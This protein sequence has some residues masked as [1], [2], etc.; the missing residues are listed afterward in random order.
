MRRVLVLIG[1][2]L[3]LAACGGGDDSTVTAS[4]AELEFGPQ[5]ALASADAT[6][7]TNP[8]IGEW[9]DPDAPAV[10]EAPEAISFAERTETGDGAAAADGANTATYALSSADAGVCVVLREFIDVVSD[11][12][13]LGDLP[14]DD[15]IPALLR[16][17]D[18]GPFGAEWT[19][20]AEVLFPSGESD[21][22]DWE[23]FGPEWISATDQLAQEQ[24]GYPAV[25]TFL[26]AVQE[27]T[28][29]CFTP[30]AEDGTRGEPV[31]D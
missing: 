30:I 14:E 3:L 29:S 1:L 31:C 17:L 7:T 26:N 13:Q 20:F 24:C 23:Q 15:T 2:S 18:D 22:A 4:E 8:P 19:R 27:T 6:A 11:P 5:V 16:S 28:Q 12:A 9:Q 10:D 21:R 25:S